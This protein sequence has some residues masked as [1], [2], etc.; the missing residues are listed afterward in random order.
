[1]PLLLS[2]LSPVVVVTLPLK[3]CQ[4]NPRS[5]E[6]NEVQV[7]WVGDEGQEDVVTIPIPSMYGIFAW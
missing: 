7:G 5:A 4:W 2:P 6:W 1:M 3:R